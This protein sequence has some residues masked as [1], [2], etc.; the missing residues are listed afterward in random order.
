MQ[1]NRI[2][3]PAMTYETLIRHT[4]PIPTGEGVAHS[5][6]YRYV[7]A[8]SEEEAFLKAHHGADDFIAC[9]D[10]SHHQGITPYSVETG[11]P[12]FFSNVHRPALGIPAD[13][14]DHRM[15]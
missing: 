9:I 13:T 5:F 2:T 6:E 15:G 1:R 12:A 11:E 3:E 7:E 10:T 8:H 4:R 14:A